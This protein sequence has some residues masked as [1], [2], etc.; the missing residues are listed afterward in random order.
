VRD[1]GDIDKLGRTNVSSR[2]HD[3]RRSILR[4]FEMASILVLLPKIGVAEDEA[5]FGPVRKLH[6]AA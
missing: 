3:D 2:Q 6:A 1:R 5:D 4:A